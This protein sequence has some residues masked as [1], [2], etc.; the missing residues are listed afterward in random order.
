MSVLILIGQL[1]YFFLPAGLANMAPVLFNQRLKKLAIPIDAGK[2]IGGQPVFGSHKTWRGVFVA[3]VM[4]G[5]LFLVQYIAVGQW[6]GLVRISAFDIRVAPWWFG[7]VF[8]FG[9]IIGDLIKSFF[10]RR[11]KVQ[12]GKSWFPFDQIDFLVGAGVVA[13]FFFDMSLPV[14]VLLL[15]IGPFFH[16]LVNHMG[17]W[18]KIKNSPW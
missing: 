14:W 6:E 8:G 1:F 12:P 18:L 16:I 17:F 4:G 5:L 2:T 7:F 13:M 9:A 15:L 3:S 10:K 11:F